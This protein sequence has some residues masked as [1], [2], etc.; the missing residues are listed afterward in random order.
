[1]FLRLFLAQLSLAYFVKEVPEELR[2]DKVW[3]TVTRRPNKNFVGLRR[4]EEVDLVAA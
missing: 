2:A 4:W 3:N 1:V